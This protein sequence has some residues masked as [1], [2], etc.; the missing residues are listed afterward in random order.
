MQP[1]MNTGGACQLAH[2]WQDDVNAAQQSL[3]YDTMFKNDRRSTTYAA[4]AAAQKY[5]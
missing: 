1:T 2:A 4:Q 3:K 5:G